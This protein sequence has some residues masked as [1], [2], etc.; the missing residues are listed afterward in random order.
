M[1]KVLDVIKLES[2]QLLA[3]KAPRIK[4]D[5]V[6]LVRGAPSIGSATLTAVTFPHTCR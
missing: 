6:Q 3:F 2:L 4:A 5:A 1:M